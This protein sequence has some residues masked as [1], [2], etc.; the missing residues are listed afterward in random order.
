MLS[1]PAADA[2]IASRKRPALAATQAFAAYEAAT[3]AFAAPWPACVPRGLTV[4]RSLTVPGGSTRVATPRGLVGVAA[5]RGL[6]GWTC[7]VG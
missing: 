7:C 5:L 2:R 6:V 3:Q 4:R 1:G